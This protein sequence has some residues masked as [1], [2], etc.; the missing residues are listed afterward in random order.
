[1][2]K[3]LNIIRLLGKY[4][5]QVV[6]NIAFNFLSTIFS[7]FTFAAIIPFLKILFSPIE[8]IVLGEAHKFS[9]SSDVIL[10]YLN[11]YLS[12]F[13]LENGTSK[14]LLVFC[15]F[16]IFIF[17]LKNITNYIALFN[18]ATIRVGVIRDLREKIHKKIL[19][20]PL[21]YF[22]EEKKG[23]II[24]RAT[25]DVSELE[26]SAVS[27]LEMLF[28]DPITI[29]IYL[30]T[31]IFMSWELT[32]FVIVLLPISGL[33]ISKIG[34]S[35]RSASLKGQAKMG[36][37]LSIFEETLTGLRIIKGFNAEG[38]KHQKFEQS[39]NGHFK[40][41]VR[42]FKRQYLSSPLT[43]IIASVLI[44]IVI[45]YG[46]NLVLANKETGFT[47]EFFITFIVIFS[48]IIVPAKSLT[49]AYFKVQKGIASIERVNEI[50]DAPN[51][52]A[53]VEHPENL[54]EFAHQIEFKN[55][56][57]KYDQ[58]IILDKLNLVAIVGPSGGGK[59]TLV[60]LLPR[61]YDVTE[62][63][64]LLDGKKIKNLSIKQLRSL[65]GIVS[66]ESILFNDTIANNI[67]LSDPLASMEK[68]ESAAKI[69]N[70]H[71]F[72]LEQ[73]NGYETNAGDGGN[74]LSG[75]QK[76][77]ISIAR[78]VL[79]NPP[80]LILDEATSALDTESEK[81]VQDA[82]VKLMQ[83]RTSFV[84]AHRLST[85]Q[86]ADKI[87]VIEKGKIIEQGTHETLLSQNGL[88]K[89]LC[90]MQSFN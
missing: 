27:S 16:V 46:G 44:A 29:I 1:M 48:Q 68:V 84:I 90:D 25:N 78:A 26:V 66:Q 87:I 76:Q 24:S 12:K 83:N 22:S 39:N 3:I 7:L 51:T 61:F 19:E 23:D 5:T 62:G 13:I 40:L 81:M 72:I 82:L 80:I 54:N 64:I 28:R 49:E 30:I 53:E 6:L 56:T 37:V 21:S 50:L 10:K 42:L 57:F 73:E 86:N 11:H 15:G 65:M 31:M 9:F 77:R 59:S 41:M 32:L 67:R 85:I 45:W 60:N 88:Y 4:K 74:K 47:G 63:E 2:K 8:N 36:E 20:L 17:L 70:A 43:E 33:L 71:Q 18:L 58:Q 52:I 89:K 69:A 79:K 35:F 55:V 75:G 38:Q 14:A 34:K